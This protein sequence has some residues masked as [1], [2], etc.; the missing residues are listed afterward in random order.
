MNK[1]EEYFI[2]RDRLTAVILANCGRNLNFRVEKSGERIRYIFW[3]KQDAVEANLE[4]I[5]QGFM[6]NSKS[7]YN[8]DKDINKE[9]LKI[10]G[11]DEKEESEEE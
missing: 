7:L 9:I 10:H 11:G 1:V 3:P 5:N 4:H 2:T 8:S 6:V